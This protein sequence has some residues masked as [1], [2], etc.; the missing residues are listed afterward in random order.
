MTKQKGSEQKL[1]QYVIMPEDRDVS[2]MQW[3]KSLGNVQTIRVCYPHH[4]HGLAGKPSNSSKPSA[5][6]DFLQF[7]NTNSQPYGRS[8][9]SVSARE[10]ALKSHESCI[11]AL[12]RCKQNWKEIT[13]LE[14]KDSKTDEEEEKLVQLKQLHCSHQYQL[15]NV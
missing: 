14:T 7:V 8:A 13:D 12:A 9:D 2:F 6:A 10:H 11:A 5:K 3:W 4:H 1:S 15:P